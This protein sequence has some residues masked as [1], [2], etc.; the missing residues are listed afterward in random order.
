MTK[1]NVV[2]LIRVSTKAQA[3]E[4]RAGLPAQRTACKEIIKRNGLT[5]KWSIEMKDVSGAAVMF[6]DEM[7]Q[8]EKIV[9]S[10][11]CCG[12]VMKEISR[13]MRPEDPADYWLLGQF[14]KY[15]VKI[16]TPD[17]IFDLSTATGQFMA[18]VQLGVAGL[19]RNTIR[20][21][22]LDAK[23]EMR[24][25]GK[26]AGAAHTLPL[27]V[28]Y[29]KKAER[30]AWDKSTIGKV[31]RLFELFTSGETN[32]KRL[33]EATGINYYSVPTLLRNPI[34][35]GVRVYDERREGTGVIRDGHEVT[36]RVKVP[37]AEVVRVRVFE[38][39][40]VSDAVFAH[41]QRIFDTKTKQ[42]WRRNNDHVDEYTYRGLLR[43]GSCDSRIIT[44]KHSPKR[45]ARVDYYACRSALGVR[46][47]SPDGGWEWRTENNTCD[48][49][50]MRRDRVEPVLDSLISTRLSDPEFL[51][52]LMTAERK[53]AL[54][55]DTR[56]K[57]E[58][59][60]GEIARNNDRLARLKS[61][62]IDGDI[63]KPEYNERKARIEAEQTACQKA[64]AECSPRMPEV[65]IETLAAICDPFNDWDGYSAEEK[66]GILMAACPVF[67]VSGLGN[68]GRGAGAKTEI[69]VHGFFLML[70]GD[71]AQREDTFAGGGLRRTRTNTDSIQLVNELGHSPTSHIIDPLVYIPLSA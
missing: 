55:G 48:T 59:L 31:E 37:E 64:L 63:D 47:H 36:R 43:C 34:Y 1:Q 16:F 57:S 53:R 51:L 28:L 21:R 58:R 5:G 67:K 10:G 20:A 4:D 39:G 61:L 32:Y 12:V 2:E 19:E 33:S 42:G 6:S 65:S 44:V 18:Q 23:K 46:G 62:L 60:N 22:T 56:K 45:D 27:G 41:A 54:S 7:R 15:R 29:E 17:Q 35:T 66:R 52:K 26:C 69:V 13:L 9:S 49:K 3:L 40:I 30:Y 8:L 50:R 24:A 70:T 25:A 68:G 14:K 11:E 38:K 71:D